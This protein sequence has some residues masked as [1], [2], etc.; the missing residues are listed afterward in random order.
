MSLMILCD[1]CSDDDINDSVSSSSDDVLVPLSQVI[2]HM[3]LGNADNV[4]L[5][6]IKTTFNKCV[7][8]H[9]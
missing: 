3:S 5:V 8:L 9:V 6:S 7:V 2:C 1:N 4:L